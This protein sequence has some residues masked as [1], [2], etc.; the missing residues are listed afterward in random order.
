MSLYIIGHSDE[1]E[2]Q[3][4]V[5]EGT[6]VRFY[7][8]PRQPLHAL[9]VL[10]V[11]S[12]RLEPWESITG[13]ALI[14]NYKI[15]EDRTAELAREVSYTPDID[16]DLYDF[17]E[18]VGVDFPSGTRLCTDP[19]G[20]A[21]RPRHECGGLLARRY[22]GGE[23]HL[24]FCRGEQRFTE[25][26]AEDKQARA[27]DML[28]EARQRWAAM[29]D[30]PWDKLKAEWGKLSLNVRIELLTAN[31]EAEDL[32]ACLHIADFAGASKLAAYRAYLASRLV[33]GDYVAN[34]MTAWENPVKELVQEGK[35]EAEQYAE[36]ALQW[37]DAG[38][39]GG[40]DEGVAMGWSW[41]ELSDQDRA[42]MLALDSYPEL[43]KTLTPGPV[44]QWLIGWYAVPINLSESQL[45]P[46]QRPADTWFEGLDWHNAVQLTVQLDKSEVS[47]TKVEYVQNEGEILLLG[48]D[49]S[50]V[51][52]EAWLRT[53]NTAER[54]ENSDESAE[55]GDEF[56]VVEVTVDDGQSTYH[57]SRVE[58][59][60]LEAAIT[61][62][63]G[64]LENTTIVWK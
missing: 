15:Y 17:V 62:W 46:M 41:Q 7:A 57:V 56:F 63:V 13:P 55:D 37:V 36:Y 25:T 22:A 18:V 24:V 12:A 16:I 10:A 47:H 51:L 43:R 30:L 2:Q 59:V 35:R 40:L 9:D 50:W 48:D 11:L 45:D 38:G 61:R 19:P 29:R 1:T 26:L 39:G 34:L 32:L 4:W 21:G 27:Q 3:A 42:H 31:S 58:D 53:L 20:C 5:P 33:Q 6:T 44:C 52:L 14:G 49:T 28:S 8:P 23:F 60:V 54:A 64:L